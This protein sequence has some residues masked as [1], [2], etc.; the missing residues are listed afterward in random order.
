MSCQHPGLRF[1]SVT[2]CQTSAHTLKCHLPARHFKVVRVPPPVPSPV[3]SALCHA[4]CQARIQSYTSFPGTQSATCPTFQRGAV[5]RHQSHLPF[6]LQCIRPAS[7]PTRS[8]SL[9]PAHTLT[10]APP[11][12]SSFP[13][14]TASPPL[15]YLHLVLVCSPPRVST[16]SFS[17][18]TTL[19][20]AT[21]K[22]RCSTSVCSSMT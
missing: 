16:F 11:A 2:A 12:R 5:S 3:P 10:H 14:G 7:S 22:Q 13:S 19:E 1:L 15:S 8:C 17:D 4:G 6:A 21:S 18:S 9:L 20:C